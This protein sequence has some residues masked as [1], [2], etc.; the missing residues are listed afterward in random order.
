MELCYIDES[1]DA[2]R[3]AMSAVSLTSPHSIRLID[4][5]L[6]RE[7]TKTDQQCATYPF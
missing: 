2:N 1:Y 3:F 6:E 7:T 5:Q 4:F